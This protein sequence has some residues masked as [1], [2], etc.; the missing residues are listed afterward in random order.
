MGKRMMRLLALATL[1]ALL[2][3]PGA[4]GAPGNIA[5]ASSGRAPAET[6]V[7]NNTYDE[8]GTCTLQFCSLR[9]AIAAA[10]NRVPDTIIFDIPT[11]DP[12]YSPRTGQWTIHLGSPLPV[13]SGSDSLAIDATSL[14]EPG[15]CQ[16]YV[17]ID[18]TGIPYGLEVT[19]ANKTLSGLVLKN[20]QSYGLYIRGSSA[21]NNQLTCSYVVSN[22][23]D[24]VRIGD[25]ANGNSIGSASASLPNVI[26]LNGEDG[27]EITGSAHDNTVTNNRIGTNEAGTSAWANGGYGVR[28]SGDAMANTIGLA[29]S[30][31][32]NLISSNGLGGILISGSGTRDNVVQYNTIGTNAGGTAALGSQ[33]DGVVISSAPDNTIGP[34]NLI[35]GHNRDGVR[36]EGGQATG[37]VV[38]GNLVGTDAAGA[39]RV[40]NK[41]LGILLQSEAHHNTIGMDADGNV[42]SGNGYN[43]D[44]AMYGG[45]GIVG[46]NFN[47]LCNNSIGTTAGRSGSLPNAG[48]GVWLSGYAQENSIGQG[49]APTQSNCANTVAWNEGDG[50]YV[51]GQG[52]VHNPIGRNSIHDNQGL[53]I[54]NESGGNE[55]LPPPDVSRYS[56]SPVGGVE[57]EA[58]ACP[59][60][61]VLVYSDDGGEGRTYE[62]SGTA[63]AT[64]G[65]FSWSG[66]P[67]EAAFTLVNTD[68][69][70]NTSEFSAALARLRLSI[71]D[72]LPGVVV[73]KVAGD[74]DTPAGQTIVEVVAEVTSWDPSLKDDVDVLVTIPGNLFG[75]PVRVFVRDQAGDSDGTTVGW[76][77]LGSGAYRA[78]DVDLLLAGSIYRRRVVLRFQIPNATSPQNVYVQGQIQVPGRAIREPD[79]TATVRIV[80]PG[81]LQA[82]IVANR[83]LLYQNYAA[84]DVTTLLNRLYTEAQGPTAS[85]SPPAAIYYVDAYSSTVRNWNN[86][87]VSYA[88]EAVANTVAN[89]I[90]D[91]IEDWHEDATQYV[92]VLGFQFPIAWPRYLLI[93]GDD[94]SLPFYRYNDPSDDEGIDLFDCDGN[95]ANGKE[96]AGWCVD[97]NANPAIRATDA[98]YL[99]TDNPYA[100]VWGNDWQMGDVELWV[101]RLLG[102]SAADMRS[103]LDQG[104]SWNNGQRGGVVMASVDGWELG[105]EPHVSGSGHIADLYDVTALLRGKGF[106]VRNDDNPTSEVR[107][108]DVMS[109]FE[110]GDASWNTNF[111]N[112]ANN[113]SGMDLF[114][115][116]GH[117]S[118]N[119]ASI[120]GS[121]FTP[122][123]TCAAATCD[124]NRFDDDHPIAMIVGCH[125]G[126]PVPNAGGLGGVND[127]MARDLV[128]EGASA[129]IGATGFSY[130]SP[131]DLHVCTWGERLMQRFFGQL[132]KPPGGNSMTI[133]K[134]LAEAKRDY[135]FGQGSNNALDRKTV[136]E[137]NIYG[138]PWAFVYYPSPSATALAAAETE[139]RAFTIADG[140]V[141]AAASAGTYSRNFTVDIAGYTAETETQGGIVYNLLSVQGGELAIA[142][143]A[144]ILPYVRAYTLTLPLGGSVTDVQ[145]VDEAHSSVGPYN[146]PI[147]QVEPWTEGGLTYTTTTDI[148]YPYPTDLVQWQ[149]TGAGVLFTFFPI[150]HN[151]T[152]DATTF[153]NYLEVRVTYEAPSS[154]AVTDFS[155]DKTH[156][157]P[158][159]TVH[160]SAIVWNVGNADV[161]LIATLTIEDTLGGTVGSQSSGAFSVPPGGSHGLALGW[162]GVLPSGSYQ[163]IVTVRSNDVVVGGA[164]AG[165]QVV[166]GQIT[167][168]VVPNVLV[169]GQE[170][171][172]QVTFANYRA[173]QVTADVQ[174]SV[175]DGH[176]LPV[177]DLPP[178]P[179]LVGAGAEGTVGFVWDSE[180]AGSGNYMAVA[181]VNVGSQA[182]GPAQQDFQ[183]ASRIYLPIVLRNHP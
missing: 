168:L 28:V 157:R 17:I 176:G 179:M 133:G 107:T 173:G 111:R 41:R 128:H 97:S 149:A 158:G 116:G 180:G 100:D 77:N 32:G 94:D 79:D 30:G 25:G 142:A 129:F 155:T 7:V 135:V 122:A 6:W 56:V 108:I 150:Q 112:A 170:A 18:A 58:T 110:G 172:F 91:L 2:V 109:P 10:N 51:Y 120:P 80:Q 105:L 139:E 65:R 48:P 5:M 151:P 86:T 123:D 63:H 132:V 14:G 52:T 69:Y 8:S 64:T 34:G 163:A 42:I 169:P 54:H 75:S 13:L 67:T 177:A 154:I 4:A 19:G 121:N 31:G 127:C 57:L 134:G 101:G 87:T 20:A 160:T 72:A 33:Q 11:D 92:N 47:T 26:A 153:F 22:A 60:C 45:V 148:A 15:N 144:P 40:S 82:I 59:G 84:N 178:Q 175:Y 104:V 93:V 90:D 103:L 21:Q 114:F 156:Y 171:N 131:N 166:D 181:T 164:S 35:S 161:T 66:T 23:V 37:N 46:S 141:A 36:I 182:Y 88:S 174:L 3:P 76:T 98:D 61:T 53:G 113:A 145:I 85:H 44:Y 146:I 138:V 50:I 73:N 162:T 38:K 81:K 159:E 96:H 152:T 106:Q 29:E 140:P 71:D 118:Y 124:Y 115:I 136:T 24:G 12:G 183:V 130:G 55:E 1:L 39:S 102:D 125:G 16:S 95:P 9:Q 165:F 62:G 43:G 89:G 49:L 70:S 143:D 68:A 137:Y 126:L 167:A 27:I 99:F 117:D 83:R 74:A 119:S 78:D 147:A